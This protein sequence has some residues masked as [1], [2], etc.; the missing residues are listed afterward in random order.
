MGLCIRNISYKGR[1][2]ILYT[3]DGTGLYEDPSCKI[4]ADKRRIRHDDGGA[5]IVGLCGILWLTYYI[6]Y[7]IITK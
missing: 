2:T 7:N 4:P 5:G 1:T 6:I 3:K